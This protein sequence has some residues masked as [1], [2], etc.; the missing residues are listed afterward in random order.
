M[1]KFSLLI[2]FLI[3]MNAIGNISNQILQEPESDVQTLPMVIGQAVSIFFIFN[4]IPMCIFFTQR[5]WFL[6]K[7]FKIRSADTNCKRKRKIV[8]FQKAQSWFSLLLWSTVVFNLIY[9]VLYGIYLN[10]TL[11]TEPCKSDNKQCPPGVEWIALSILIMQT[12][13]YTNYI[14]CCILLFVSM[15]RIHTTIKSNYKHWNTDCC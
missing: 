6:Y 8:E 1:V 3:A 7:R 10:Y 2:V 13:I 14:V 15:K 5:Q 9:S 11:L 12:L 4:Y